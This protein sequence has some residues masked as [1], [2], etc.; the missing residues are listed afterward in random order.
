MAKLE[1][2]ISD[3]SSFMPTPNPAIIFIGIFWTGLLKEIFSKEAIV[4]ISK[5][6][7]MSR[8]KPDL[9]KAIPKAWLSSF[10]N[11]TEWILIFLSFFS[12]GIYIIS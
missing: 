4:H 2:H 5:F 1:I 7:V 3:V 8:S 12:L 10:K 11:P 9:A 6:C